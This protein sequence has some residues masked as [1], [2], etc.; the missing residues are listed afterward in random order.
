V[1]TSAADSSSGERKPQRAGDHQ[2]LDLARALA[3]LE[4]LRVPV[5]ASRPA[6]HE[7]GTPEHNVKVESLKLIVNGNEAAAVMRNAGEFDR[8]QDVHESIEIYQ[9]GDGTMHVRYFTPDA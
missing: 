4:D 3:D 8:R 9:F 2:A 6:F 5:Q 7:A 1:P